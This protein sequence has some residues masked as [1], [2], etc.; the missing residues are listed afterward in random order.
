MENNY[1]ALLDL[2]FSWSTEDKEIIIEFWN[3]G[4]SIKYI[5]EKVEREVDE[6][7][8]LLLDLARKKK[9]KERDNGI[10]GRCFQTKG[11]DK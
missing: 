10:W 11:D 5:S 4:E 9:I 1:I 2:D 8:L 6:V 3:Q 7:F